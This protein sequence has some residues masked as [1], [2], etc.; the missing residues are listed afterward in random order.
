MRSGW[1]AGP[2]GRVTKVKKFAPN[3]TAQWSY[4]DSAGI[5]AAVNFEFTPDGF[6]RLRGGR[7]SEASTVPPRS[8]STA[9]R[10]GVIR[11]SLAPPSAIVTVICSGILTWFTVSSSLTAAPSSRR[12]DLRVR[13]YGRTTYGIGGLRV[14]VGTDNRA[15]VS[16]FPAPVRR[17]PRSSKL[18]ED[19]GLVWSNLDA[20]GP[21]MLLLPAQM[22]LDGANNAY[23]AAGTLLKMAVCKVNS[24]GTSAWTQTVA[25]SGHADAIVLGDNDD[26]AFS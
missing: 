7:S 8:T 10:C 26:L 20:D 23:L 4:F 17:A 15:V 9:T 6:S 12:L 25:G 19:G 24:D 14:E 5:G 1:V 11:E 13:W 2:A 21:L 3:G 22:L 18:D 16:G